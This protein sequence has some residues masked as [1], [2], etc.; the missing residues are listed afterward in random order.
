[1]RIDILVS[2]LAKEEKDEFKK[3]EKELELR[4]LIGRLLH[5]QGYKRFVIVGSKFLNDNVKKKIKL[6]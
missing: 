2:V 3:Y 6:D 5:E 1:M 4:N